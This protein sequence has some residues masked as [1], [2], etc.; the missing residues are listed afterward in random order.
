MV[1]GC[2]GKNKVLACFTLLVRRINAS[3]PVLT[4]TVFSPKW[5]HPGSPAASSPPFLRHLPACRERFSLTAATYFIH[6]MMAC[7]M[8]STSRYSSRVSGPLLPS[9]PSVIS[10]IDMAP[11]LCNIFLILNN[12]N[13]LLSQIYNSHT[14][15]Q[16]K[17]FS[18]IL[19][20]YEMQRWI[21]KSEAVFHFEHTLDVNLTE[22]WSD[23]HFIHSLF[24]FLK[25]KGQISKELRSN[26][27]IK[28]F[29]F[30]YD[31]RAFFLKKL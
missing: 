27:S 15:K 31:T 11:F 1:S 19:F 2:T 8:C 9:L 18:F 26:P 13:R 23:T 17:G 28:I 29:W 7:G 12:S 3:D 22:Q 6:R 4:L 24:L 21:L 5:V 20:A 16:R 25:R 30:P 14:M 10:E